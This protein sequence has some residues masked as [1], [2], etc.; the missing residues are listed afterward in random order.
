MNFVEVQ[1]RITKMTRNEKLN[2]FLSYAHDVMIGR[3][4]T[5][6]IDSSQ[7]TQLFNLGLLRAQQLGFTSLTRVYGM[8]QERHEAG[9]RAAAQREEMVQHNLH[10]SPPAEEIT[11]RVARYA[12]QWPGWTRIRFEQELNPNYS[13]FIRENEFMRRPAISSLIAFFTS[14]VFDRRDDVVVITRADARDLLSRTADLAHFLN[15]MDLSRLATERYVHANA[16]I[17]AM[18]AARELTDLAG[19]RDDIIVSPWDTPPPQRPGVRVIRF[20]KPERTV[21][22]LVDAME[23]TPRQL[24]ITDICTDEA[25]DSESWVEE[26]LNLTS[27]LPGMDPTN[28]G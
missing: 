8:R 6:R 11:R 24:L 14:V 18:E 10:T 3:R 5:P 9:M 26:F 22:D 20:Q 19:R 7:A 21:E 16:T 12:A 13:G 28:E 25:H 17:R 27:D 2:A 4:R 23:T 15:I 1:R